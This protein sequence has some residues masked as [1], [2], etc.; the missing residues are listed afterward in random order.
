MT[1]HC[2]N[3]ATVVALGVASAAIPLYTPRWMQYFSVQFLGVQA[4]ISSYQHLD[5]LFTER[6]SVGGRGL[7]YSDTGMIAQ[8]LL[9][10]YWF[11]GGLLAFISL[12]FL[13][14]GLRAV[15][16]QSFKEAKE[17]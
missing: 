4:C 10:P 12:I 2:W 3:G 14:L 1:V 8:Q 13:G 16:R 15:M 6:V 11:W 9:L 7:Q 5:Y 17:A